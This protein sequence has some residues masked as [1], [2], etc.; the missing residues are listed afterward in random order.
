MA[1]SSPERSAA[2]RRRLNR[3]YLVMHPPVELD[4]VTARD[5]ADRIA[6]VE[7]NT[8]IVIDLRDLAFCGSKGIGV[9]V[10]AAQAVERRDCSLTLSS[11]P[12]HFDRLLEVCGLAEHFEVR[13]PTTSRRRR[14][15]GGADPS[16]R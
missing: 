6:D 10:E 8:D 12:P 3:Q 9:L 1:L 15:A 14:A 4:E 16:R 7:P 2:I 13:R 11:P 5:F